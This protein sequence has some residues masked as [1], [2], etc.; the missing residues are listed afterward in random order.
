[1][2]KW[3]NYSYTRKQK[4]F[5]EKYL[6][7]K[8][9]GTQA[10]IQAD[11][12][13]KSAGVSAARL[14]TMDKIQERIQYLEV[15]RNQR[16]G[17]LNITTDRVALEMARLA[18]YD[19]GNIY[20]G[21]GTLKDIHE[22]DEDTRRALCSVKV[23][24]EKEYSKGARSTIR[25]HETLEEYKMADKAKYLEMLGRYLTMFHDKLDLAIHARA[26]F[27]PEPDAKK[28]R[29]SPPGDKS[30]ELKDAIVKVMADGE[31]QPKKVI[32]DE[33]R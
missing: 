7:T 31:D 10:A 12:S 32:E 1:M 20:H 3:N 23:T 21:D 24:K 19:I 11:F 30:M 27:L 9:N 6:N 16:L 26:F 14:L 8:G 29:Q 28:A 4:I 33:T 22:I 15:E 5:C 2:F 25:I 18:F 17:D 13:E